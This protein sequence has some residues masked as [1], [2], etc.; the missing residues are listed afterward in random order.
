MAKRSNSSATIPFTVFAILLIA[1]VGFHVQKQLGDNVLG[2]M[3]SSAPL[4]SKEWFAEI[5]SFFGLGTNKTER[6]AV[7]YSLPTYGGGQ[8]SSGFSSTG[9]AESDTL[10]V[11][12]E[13]TSDDGGESEFDSLEKE[14][15]GL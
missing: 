4:F 15:A 8:K 5:L 14:A 11:E 7:Q 9:N 6:T 1:I 3:T 10:L 12:L 2:E 13:S